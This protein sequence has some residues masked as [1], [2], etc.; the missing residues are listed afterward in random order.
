MIF[1]HGLLKFFGGGV[2]VVLREENLGRTA[3]Q[4]DHARTS[5][6]GFEFC[7]VVLDLQGDFVF[8]LAFLDVLSIQHLHVFAVKGGGHGLDFGKKRFH[9]RQVVRVQHVVLWCDCLVTVREKITA[10]V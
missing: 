7:D 6:L 10:A 9:H 3:P 4:H 1:L 5:V 8:V 2:H